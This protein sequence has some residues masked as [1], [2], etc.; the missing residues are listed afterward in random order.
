MLRMISL[1]VVSAVSLSACA[2]AVTTSGEGGVRV[3]NISARDANQIPYRVLDTVN[4]LR[5]ARGVSPVALSSEL[6]AAASTHARDMSVQNR[7]WHFGSDGSS[8]LDRVRRTGYSGQFLGEN[9]S[10]TFESEIETVSAWMEQP[11]TRN[12][13]LAPS[14]RN[15]GVAWYQEPNGKIWWTLITG[16]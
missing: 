4:E 14:A 16:S 7:P 13:I 2:P 6:T 10:E 11:D 9:I 15:L 3:Y 5:A 12:V 8:P 1:I